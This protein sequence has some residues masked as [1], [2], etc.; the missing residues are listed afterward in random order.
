MYFLTYRVIPPL[1]SLVSREQLTMGVSD[2]YIGQHVIVQPCLDHCAY[3]IQIIGLMVEIENMK[4]EYDS[5]TT[6]LLEWIELTVVRLSNRSFPN[7]LP[8]MQQ[9]M[10]DFKMYRTVEK[11]PKYVYEITIVYG[12]GTL[13]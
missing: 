5:M 12:L 10:A 2:V 13:R 4:T 11:P 6:K 1:Y 8:D 7:S 3:S 9:L